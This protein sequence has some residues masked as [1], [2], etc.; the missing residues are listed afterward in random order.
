MTNDKMT[1]ETI[2]HSQFFHDSVFCIKIEKRNGIDSQI[3]AMSTMKFGS[4]SAN[5]CRG[6]AT[7]EYI[8]I[9]VFK[10]GS[11]PTALLFGGNHGDEYEGP[12]TLIKLARTI[13]PEQVKGALSFCRC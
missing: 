2:L 8:P 5:G 6:W 1:N 12:V 3:F 9:V 7:R 13:Q 4:R 11:G 10:N